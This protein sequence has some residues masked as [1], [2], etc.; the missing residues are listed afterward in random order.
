MN[1]RPVKNHGL[2]RWRVDFGKELLP[3][4]KWQRRVKFF[5]NQADA[6]AAMQRAGKDRLDVGK[7]WADLPAERRVEIVTILDEMENAGVTARQVWDTYRA[8]K[9]VT[10]NEATKRTLRQCIEELIKSRRG[11]NRRENY[12]KGL[13]SYLN[14]FAKGREDKRVDSFTV[15]DI[16][17]WFDSRKEANSTRASNLFRLSSLFDMAWRRG[18][19]T[20]N[21]VLRVD[22]VSVEAKAAQIF[23][24]EQCAN[25]LQWVKTNEPDFLGWVSLALCAGLRPEEC[26]KVDVADLNF[27]N[28]TVRITGEMSKVRIRSRIVH[29]TPSAEAWLK[30][31][32][33][34]GARW[35]MPHATR[36][37]H[38]RRLRDWLKL[39]KW[40]Q[41]IL[42]HTAASHMM[43]HFED[44][45]KVA[46][47]LGNSEKIMH[48]H[49]KELVTKAD[50]DRF[51]G[52]L[53]G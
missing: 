13:E 17:A 15:R 21:V 11:A 8:E 41:D 2:D 12:V 26:D 32:V 16:E 39:E 51:V 31:A 44:V 47:E 7:R 19:A 40:P 24:V 38:L 20:E 1:M 25:I 35:K 22:R 45:G 14:Q 4:G 37:R 29:F 28:N 36:R 48:Q 5:E 23:N 42:R 46:R 53:P 18:F 43:A 34:S 49:Y 9:M 6:K 33:Q 30:L 3:N 52:L 50:G 10:E 27:K